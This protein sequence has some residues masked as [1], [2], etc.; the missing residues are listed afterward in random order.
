MKRSIL[1]VMQAG[2]WIMTWCY[3]YRQTTSVLLISV[4]FVK[5]GTV[6][7]LVQRPHGIK[8]RAWLWFSLV[9]AHC[10]RMM[11]LY[12]FSPWRFW[13]MDGYCCVDHPSLP[14]FLI[15][16]LAHLCEVSSHLLH[17]H[18]AGITLIWTLRQSAAQYIRAESFRHLYW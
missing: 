18:H 14:L 7:V 17:L 3:G 8:P 2:S 16:L 1:P 15:L 5:K 10:W 13:K 12:H 9:V 4:D 11:C 6:P